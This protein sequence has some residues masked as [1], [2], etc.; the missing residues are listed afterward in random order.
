LR[1][2]EKALA[3][4]NSALAIKPGE[5]D[6]LANRDFVLKRLNPKTIPAKANIKLNAEEE[7]QLIQAYTLYKQK[8]YQQALSIFEKLVL[9]A[10]QKNDKIS[11]MSHRNNIGLCH[12]KMGN[13]AKAEQE[14]KAVIREDPQNHKAH[15]NLKLLYKTLKKNLNR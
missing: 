5:S 1:E 7:Q 13:Y 12:I 10:K 2:F 4:Y 9:S 6:F 15:S 11:E 14:L 3:D 8:N